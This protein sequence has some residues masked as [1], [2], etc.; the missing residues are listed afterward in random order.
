MWIITALSITGIILNI[1]KH[2]ACYVIWS[3]TNV[4]WMIYD[5]RIG[6]YP[7]AFMFAVYLCLSVWGLFA[8]THLWGKGHDETEG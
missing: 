2:A 1:K 8:W 5:I 7:Q 6:A 4:S 3:I